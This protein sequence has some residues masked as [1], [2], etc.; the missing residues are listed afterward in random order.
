M[1][2]SSAT[3]AAPSPRLSLQQTELIA[4]IENDPECM[5]AVELVYAF[6]YREETP[7]TA[8]YTA[9]K[10][11]LE[12]ALTGLLARHPLLDAALADEGE[13]PTL[14]AGKA[15]IDLE[16]SDP[17]EDAFTAFLLRQRIEVRE[18]S[19]GAPVFRFFLSRVLD[20]WMIGF[21]VNHL[22]FDGWSYLILCRDLSLL[23][24]H[25]RNGDGPNRTRLPELTGTY[26]TYCD[27]Q[28]ETRTAYKR[29][30]ADYWQRRPVRAHKGP[31]LFQDQ[32]PLA[33][34]S[35]DHYAAPLDAQALKHLAALATANRCPQFLVLMAASAWAISAAC[36]QDAIMCASNAV[37]RTE[38]DHF[39]QVGY[40]TTSRFALFDRSAEQSFADVLASMREDWLFG[41]E[42]ADRLYASDHQSILGH[43][44][45]LKINALDLPGLTGAQSNGG[46]SG[47]LQFGET[48]AQRI[49]VARPRTLWREL[50][51][52]WIKTGAGYDFSAYY[53]PP[54]PEH[55]VTSLPERVSAIL[56]EGVEE[57]DI[58]ARPK[59]PS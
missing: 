58:A 51:I 48:A 18:L 40:Y 11:A 55:L 5:T 28:M 34:Q 25:A 21:V 15:V 33:T 12:T 26:D 37:G 35:S 4:R 47:T 54:T 44:Y 59:E 13:G 57:I 29:R 43:P 20:H 17:S 6:R 1:N 38:A 39:N 32:A 50:D 42:C 22:V 31:S 9:F 16:R 3:Q 10:T 14:R 52:T 30:V 45:L 36:G 46:L 8:P 2:I 56:A 24:A 53:R 27:S 7:E 49:D 41:V 19:S 23:Y